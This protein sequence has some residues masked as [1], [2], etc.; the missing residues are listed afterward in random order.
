M[1][2]SRSDQIAIVRQM[3]IKVLCDPLP[4]ST[5]KS[6][7]ALDIDALTARDL[8]VV[9]RALRI[10]E[11]TRPQTAAGRRTPVGPQRER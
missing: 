3:L 2:K 7:M 1:P 6:K 4:K 5:L 10:F 8:Y 9:G 11:A